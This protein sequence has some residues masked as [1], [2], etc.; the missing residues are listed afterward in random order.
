MKI[1]ANNP[2]N[3]NAH[4]TIKRLPPAIVKSV[5]VVYAY[6]VK[7]HVIPSVN[8]AAIKTN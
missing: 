7:E 5:F 8:I 4:P 3:I 1:A 6:K 2:N